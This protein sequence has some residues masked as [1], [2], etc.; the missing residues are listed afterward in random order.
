MAKQREYK[1]GQTWSTHSLTVKKI[2]IK[3]KLKLLEKGIKCAC[4]DMEKKNSMN[5][6]KLNFLKDFPPNL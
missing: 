1:L 3:L 4:S 5:S 2:L 6:A